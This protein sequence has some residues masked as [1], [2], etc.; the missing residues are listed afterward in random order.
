MDF[1]ITTENSSDDIVNTL[2]THGLAVCHNHLDDVSAI[3]D[4][5]ERIIEQ[6]E[7]SD[8]RQHYRFG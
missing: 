4:E 8:Y 5:C 2:K 1:N 3:K 7:E 6:T